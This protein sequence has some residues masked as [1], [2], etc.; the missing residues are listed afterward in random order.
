MTRK[1][2]RKDISVQ[3]TRPAG[4]LTSFVSV[5]RGKLKAHP[6]VLPTLAALS[7]MIPAVYLRVRMLL[8][9][10]GKPLDPDAEAYLDLAKRTSWFRTEFREP[11]YIWI[12]K[13]W[14]LFPGN[15]ETILRI[16]SFVAGIACT[17]LIFWVA[18]QWFGLIGGWIA[19]LTYAFSPAMVFT[20][21]RG[22]REEWII[23]LFLW[24]AVAY[25]ATWGKPWTWKVALRLGIPLALSS[26]M[27]LGTLSI[28]PLVIF[29]HIAWSVYKNK[30]AFKQW[31]GPF[32]LGCLVSILPIVPYLAYCQHKYGD[33]FHI[34]NNIGA[35]F[36][37]NL[38]FAGKHPDFPTKEEV[39]ID[40]YCGG[41]I[42]MAEYMFKYHTIGQVCQRFCSSAHRLYLGDFAYFHFPLWHRTRTE[43][44][45]ILGN[46]FDKSSVRQM[47]NIIYKRPPNY[48][49]IN[50]LSV[51]GFI[52][53]C[54]S[55]KGRLL[56]WLILL[57]HIQ[58]LFFA[59]LPDFDWRLTTSFFP[60]L[61]FAWGV[62]GAQIVVWLKK[63]NHV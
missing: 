37:A 54:F 18:W 61:S 7:V 28:T 20:C 55:P 40:S 15:D 35:R 42:T 26:L 48:A 16:S 17:F 14:Q 59:A 36:Y 45:V 51:L 57:F 60:Y 25:A 33:A 34:S 50:Y 30:Q 22:L 56:T 44:I 23:L 29:V 53:L 21:V 19:G 52:V 38:E 6:W 58:I 63:L 4:A 43:V 1:N 49:I 10:I 3:T 11:L 27:R 9:V 5:W 8:D 2:A 39:D 62:L 46:L 41:R 31:V 12:V 13:F 47:F 32:I 24:F